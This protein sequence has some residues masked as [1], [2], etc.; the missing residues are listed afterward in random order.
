LCIHW[1]GLI[2]IFF[3]LYKKNRFFFFFKKK[4]RKKKSIFVVFKN[5]GRKKPICHP[6]Q[7]FTD[8]FYS[9]SEHCCVNTHRQL[10]YHQKLIPFKMHSLELVISFD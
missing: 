9:F 8:F 5:P 7:E 3:L 6:C 2:F 1:G 4:K 10:H